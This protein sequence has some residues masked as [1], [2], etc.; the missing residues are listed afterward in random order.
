M[1]NLNI[2]HRSEFYHREEDY[3]DWHYN[4]SPIVPGIT[5]D[6][7]IRTVRNAENNDVR[8]SE[9]EM[10][11]NPICIPNRAAGRSQNCHQKRP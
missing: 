3:Y 4:A 11:A 5:A 9:R 7:A 6:E 8:P 1:S 10:R 2:C